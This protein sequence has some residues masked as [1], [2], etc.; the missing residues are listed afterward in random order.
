[1]CTGMDLQSGLRD[2]AWHEGVRTE[3]HAH[4]YFLVWTQPIHQPKAPL[5]PPF[6]LLCIQPPIGMI[7]P[8]MK[9]EKRV[10]YASVLL[11]CTCVQLNQS[12]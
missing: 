11:Q 10:S 9:N 5:L 6:S 4:T 3:N 2:S 1:M 8:L 12:N 7:L